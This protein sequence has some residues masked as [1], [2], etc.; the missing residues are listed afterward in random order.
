MGIFHIF[1]I[2]QMVPN[3]TTHHILAL[4]YRGFKISS[5]L[6]LAVFEVREAENKYF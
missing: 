6:K 5:Y 1:R 2:V 4:W 3:R